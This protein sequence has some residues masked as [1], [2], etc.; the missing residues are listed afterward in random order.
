MIESTEGVIEKTL[1]KNRFLNVVNWEKVKNLAITDNYI[2]NIMQFNIS[3]QGKLVKCF[4]IERN[5]NNIKF[6]DLLV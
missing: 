3:P 1:K 4:D 5:E 2:K 6:I